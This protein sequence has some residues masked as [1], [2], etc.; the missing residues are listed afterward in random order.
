MHRGVVSDT[1]ADRV[2]SAAIDEVIVADREDAAVIIEPDFDIMQL[3]ARMGG[4]HQMFAAILD[5]A[6]RP[7]KPMS[8]KGDQQ[9]FGIDVSLAAKAAADI[10]RDA[11]HPC[12]R[13]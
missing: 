11:A 1:G 7:A 6:H 3:I 13:Q 10:E 4:A 5:P 2:P 12:L 8:E 9:V